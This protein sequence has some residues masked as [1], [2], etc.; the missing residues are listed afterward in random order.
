ME[1]KEGIWW[2][3]EGS[4]GCG[5]A[6]DLSIFLVVLSVLIVLDPYI[7]LTRG[8][9]DWNNEHFFEISSSL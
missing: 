8:S 1:V 3:R 9:A 5:K 6:R 7:F 2:L 4:V